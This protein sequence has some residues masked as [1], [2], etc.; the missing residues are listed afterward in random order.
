MF[1]CFTN[2]LCP[3]RIATN[4]NTSLLKDNFSYNTHFHN[5]GFA[6]SLVLKAR[7]FGTR[8]WPIRTKGVSEKYSR[9][10]RLKFPIKVCS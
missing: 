10:R 4:G 3:I 1:N 7:V 6:L 8:K 2:C 5:K 9:H